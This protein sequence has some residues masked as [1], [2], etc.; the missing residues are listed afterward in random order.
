MIVCLGERKGQRREGA[1]RIEYLVVA[2][3]LQRIGQGDPLLPFLLLPIPLEG[4]L[5]WSLRGG[6]D[7]PDHQ[8]RVPVVELPDDVLERLFVGFLE[9]P[10]RIS[11]RPRQDLVLHVDP[12]AAA[13]NLP[14]AQRPPLADAFDR[15]PIRAGHHL[16]TEEI[17]E[18][19]LP[20]RL[21]VIRQDL[22]RQLRHG[23]G[24]EGVVVARRLGEVEFL[25][26]RGSNGE[27]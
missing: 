3:E 9:R 19:R 18:V 8:R 16:Q 14:R 27:E 22:L 2:N 15:L 21:A 1:K 11:L 10:T 13:G 20:L 12:V 25:R 26:H 4:V 17:V 6:T 23:L 24:E 5:H 7:R